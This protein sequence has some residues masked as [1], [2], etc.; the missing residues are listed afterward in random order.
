MGWTEIDHLRRTAIETAETTNTKAL[1]TENYDGCRMWTRRQ[2]DT[3]YNMY[4]EGFAHADRRA[5]TTFNRYSGCLVLHYFFVFN[6]F[7]AYRLNIYH[8]VPAAVPSLWAELYAMV[9]FLAKYDYRHMQA[10]LPPCVRTYWSPPTGSFPGLWP[11]REDIRAL[12]KQA[13]SSEYLHKVHTW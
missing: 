2:C 9:N 10:S 1:T 3:R 8:Y 5:E 4:I 6:F 12:G 11:P 7:I 13:A